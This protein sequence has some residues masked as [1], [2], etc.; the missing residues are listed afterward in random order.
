MSFSMPSLDLDNINQANFNQFLRV[1]LQID[2]D[3]RTDA[4]IDAIKKC[5]INLEFFKNIVHEDPNDEL[6]SLEKGCRMLGYRKSPKGSLLTLYKDIAR[7]FFITLK[8]KIGVF[9]PRS[10][11]KCKRER[12][13]VKWVYKKIGKKHFESV[14]DGM[15][16]ALEKRSVN[17]NI[18][19]EEVARFKMIKG[20]G[21]GVKRRLVYRE[22][23]FKSV[24]GGLV[25]EEVNDQCKIFSE[26]DSVSKTNQTHNQLF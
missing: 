11:E 7:E 23:Y 4:E 5:T 2:P 3:E 25:E 18:Y 24:S 15:L 22:E 17:N 14:T 9:V 19:R 12:E 13:A 26:E 16:R 20:E 8:G 10:R 21:E 1:L 6:G